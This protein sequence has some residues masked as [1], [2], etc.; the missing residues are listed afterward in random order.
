MQ[1][2]VRFLDQTSFLS[3]YHSNV[4]WHEI[5]HNQIYENP[6]RNPSRK[7][8]PARIC[9]IELLSSKSTTS[10]LGSNLQGVMRKKSG[11]MN[12]PGGS[13][14]ILF[15]GAQPIR[16]A[17]F[18]QQCV[19]GMETHMR[20]E[21]RE[22]ARKAHLKHILVRLMVWKSGPGSEYNLRCLGGH[23]KHIL[24]PSAFEAFANPAARPLAS[25]I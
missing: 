19:W 16:C 8:T 17:Q 4:L 12:L 21:Q 7:Q 13:R 22:T 23:L 20:K 1:S 10:K 15:S 6:A 25:R 24:V 2:I 14:R 9:K 3:Y 18:F 11:A 5:L